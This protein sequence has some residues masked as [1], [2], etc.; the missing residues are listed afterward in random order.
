MSKKYFLQEVYGVDTVSDVIDLFIADY[1]KVKD[2]NMI[3]SRKLFQKY[4][5]AMTYKSTATSIAGSLSRFRKAIREQGGKYE[6]D[7]LDSFWFH[8]LYIFN[9]DEAKKRKLE[10][11]KNIH[12]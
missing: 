3:E 10:K 11:D 9:S 4:V 5:L 12:I 1:N 7:T 6:A 2:T 8:E